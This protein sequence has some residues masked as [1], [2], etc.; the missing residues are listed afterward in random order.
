MIAASVIAG[1]A[2]LGI[3]IGLY[4]LPSIVAHNRGV[5]SVGSIVVINLFLGWT[6][7][8]WVVALAMAMR[9][10][11]PGSRPQWPV[12]GQTAQPPMHPPAMHPPP[13]QQDEDEDIRRPPD[14][15]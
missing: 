13:P 8:G 1:L 2:V 11:P 4:F 5:S 6:F 14:R 7:I 10:P 3:L 9:T 12:P 15:L